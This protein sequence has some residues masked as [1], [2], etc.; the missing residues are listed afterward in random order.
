MSESIIPYLD[1]PFAFF[2]H[3]MGAMISFE[4]ARQLRREHR[5]LPLHL[6][7]SGQRA[8]HIPRTD[9]PRYNLPE[10]EFIRELKRLKGTP[11]EILEH[12]EL[13]QLLIP[14]LRSDFQ[15]CHTYEYSPEAPLEC[16][17]TAL[18]GFDDEEV[19]YGRLEGWEEQ[20]TSSFSLRVMPGDHFYLIKFKDLF[21]RTLSCEIRE[22][23]KSL[24]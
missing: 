2:G 19:K 3:S 22:A 18:G 5:P 20:T 13:M 17:I 15:I 23:L 12:A 4:L 8:P 21:F 7:I 1:K 14:M 9:P 16:S 10:P 6:F 11:D 24:P